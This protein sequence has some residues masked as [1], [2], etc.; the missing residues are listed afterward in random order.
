MVEYKKKKIQLQNGGSRNY[1]YKEYSDGKKKQVSKEE[2]LSAR[3]G[4]NSNKLVNRL[5]RLNLV[6]P[7]KD[8]E[9]LHKEELNRITRLYRNKNS[10]EKFIN[11][12]ESLPNY[13]NVPTNL[14]REHINIINKMKSEGNGNIE[15]LSVELIKKYKSKDS[16]RKRIFGSF[17]ELDD[18]QG[19][20][21]NHY[22]G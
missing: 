13:R 12:Y 6:I 17:S 15:Q 5:V 19:K 18:Y 2:F 1:Y 14:N 3:G 22:I 9:I 16:E 8:N 4:D 10:L 20:I 7:K 11:E 21:F